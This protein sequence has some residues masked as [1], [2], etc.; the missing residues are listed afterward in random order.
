MTA[1]PLRLLSVVLLPILVGACVAPPPTPALSYSI[2]AQPEGSSGYTDKPGWHTQR[3][4]VAAANPLA[5][6][7]GLQVLRAGGSAVDAAIAVQMVLTLVEPQSSGIG[8]G[9]FLLHYDGQNVAAFDGRET[10]PA[11]ATENLFLQ[12]DGKP[13]PFMAAVV[14]GRSVGVPGTV[15]MLE[16]AHRQHGKL[17]WAQLFIPAITLADNGF[18][19]SPRLHTL[20]ASETQLA[21]D[22]AA[23]AYF[24]DA[25]GKPWP[26][27][28]VL[29]NPELAAVLR[30]LATQGSRALYEGPV[31]QA[32]VAK[33]QGHPTNPGT[34]SMVDLA[35][36]QPVQRQALCHPY[37]TSA[38][39]HLRLCGFPPPSSGAIA[40]GQ[41][42]GMLAHTPA[43]TL[44]L[45]TDG[46]PTPQW[47]HWYTEA[48][49]LAFAD[50]AQYVAD[51][52]FVSAPGGDWMSM[53]APDYL[54]QRARSIGATSM[55]V[56]QPG[57]PGTVRTSFA[58]MPA[59]PEYGTSHISVVDA[60][61]HAV[62]MTTTIED[63]FGA[64]QL[65][66]GFLLNNELTDFSF[67]P[68]DAQGR[69]IANRVEPGKRP[70][71]SMSPT[72]VFDA[73]TKALLM[74]GGSPGGA[75][76][77]HYT[78]KTL[79]GTFNW[80]LNAQ[81]AINLPNFG[82]TNGPTVLEEKRFPAAT[83]QSLQAMGHEVRE[84]GM[85]SGL[86]AIQKTSTGFFGGADPR[87]EGVVL[88]D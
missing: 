59:Q 20:L 56:A 22:P 75:L 72:L 31:A 50:R 70:R 7:A 51:P 80:G 87:R 13:M 74:S 58:P 71:S 21:K 1:F 4:A 25:S 49:R 26:V 64:R 43:Q 68:R 38:G 36:Y 33:V 15:R 53:L 81:Q 16:L 57:Q 47:L 2:P 23:A 77:I 42:L 34:L 35:N 63:A 61:G 79:W 82:S 55:K 40:I 76:I 6:D 41:M 62:A 12:P 9:A 28:H 27:G 85:P 60:Q 39:R 32:M 5:T 54:A 3:F 14:G 11:A 73:D 52:A 84:I 48:A 44:P 19:V 46:L 83:L 8:G 66:K 86:Q 29:R 78:A 10:A 17:P 30:A 88:G 69:P 18:K 37:T 65:V 24:F 67:A 45:G